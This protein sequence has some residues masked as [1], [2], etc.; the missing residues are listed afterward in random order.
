LAQLVNRTTANA[1]ALNCLNLLDNIYS[2]FVLIVYNIY[3]RKKYAAR[4]K[5]FVKIIVCCISLEL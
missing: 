2:P 1:K 4:F 5:R 3:R